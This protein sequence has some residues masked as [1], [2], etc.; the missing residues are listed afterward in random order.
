MI[1][2]P[3]GFWYHFFNAIKPRDRLQVSEWADEYRFIPRGTSPEPGQWATARTPYLREPMDCFSDV[4]TETI[5]G[6]FSSQT[7]KSECIINV[8]GF[9]VDQDPSPIL[10]VDPTLDMGCRS[11]ALKQGGHRQ[12][13]RRSWF[14]GLG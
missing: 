13:W 5:I 9:F 10:L 14:R 12:H 7:A 3:K 1:E 2:K 6:M 4:V 8:I 11:R